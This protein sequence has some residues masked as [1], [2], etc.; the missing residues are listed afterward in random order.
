[1]SC[2][3]AQ[4]PDSRFS[5]TSSKLYLVLRTQEMDLLLAALPF[6]PSY[7]TSDSL[8]HSWN[9]SEGTRK[10]GLADPI[11]ITYDSAAKWEIQSH[12]HLCCS[13]ESLVEVNQAI[14]INDII[15]QENLMIWNTR[16][17]GSWL[18]LLI[19]PPLYHFLKFPHIRSQSSL[20]VFI[21]QLSSLLLLCVH[22]A[23]E[24]YPTAMLM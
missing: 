21:F 4:N 3:N 2:S 24:S 11:S 10:V 6:Q 20:V 8:S 12:F 17:S 18:T 19:F 23:I 16:I 15:G 22:A 7:S 9:S 14:I 1:M 13:S 5:M